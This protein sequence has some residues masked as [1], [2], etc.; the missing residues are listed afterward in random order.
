MN[1]CNY[2]QKEVCEVGKLKRS[3][4][5]GYSKASV[6]GKIDELNKQISDLSQ[7]NQVQ[8]ELISDLKKVV[9]SYKER[10]LFISEALTEAKKLSRDI[11]LDSELKASELVRITEQELSDKVYRTEVSL[12]ELEQTKQM[13]IEHEE[14]MKV[15]LKQ[16]LNKHIE[17]VDSIDI[18]ALQAVS[19]KVKVELD[20]SVRKVDKTRKIFEYD[21]VNVANEEDIPVFT[22]DDM[23]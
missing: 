19:K 23:A 14:F 5:F 1:S 15:E 7:R 17:M 4:L 18:L 13:I 2:N 6:H 8:E 10:E 11:L 9:S 3:F 22:F 20:N 21:D 16:L 12:Q